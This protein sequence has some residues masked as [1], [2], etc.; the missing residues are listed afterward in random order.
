[1]KAFFTLLARMEQAATA[2][3]ESSVRLR[4]AVDLYPHDPHQALSNLRAQVPMSAAALA[5]LERAREEIGEVL[6]MDLTERQRQTIVRAARRM[7]RRLR[8][9]AALL[10]RF[11]QKVCGN[12]P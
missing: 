8:E 9:R 2:A 1:M 10:Q 12:A 11:N 7:N 6:A 3:R 4:A 5:D